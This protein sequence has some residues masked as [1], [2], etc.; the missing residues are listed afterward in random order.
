MKLKEFNIKTDVSPAYH[1]DLLK[2]LY[3]Y[4]LLPNPAFTEA[5]IIYN[6]LIF[7]FQNPKGVIRGRIMIDGGV[8]ISMGYTRHMED[9]V[10]ELYED[11]FLAIQLFEEELEESTIYF[12]WVE[13][14]EIIPEKPPSIGKRA[15][16]SLFGSSLLLLYILF[17]GVNIILFIIL[18]FYA[19]IAILL[20]QFSIILFSDKIYSRMGEWVITPENPLIHILMYQLPSDDFQFFKKVAGED[21]IFEIKKEIYEKSFTQ[22]RF[23]TCELGREILGRYGLGLTPLNEKSKVVDIY[24]LVKYVAFRFG[25]PTPKIVISNTLLPNAAATGPS[26]H[27]GLVL[28]TTG[29]IA[30]LDEDEIMSVIGHEIAHLVGRDPLILFGII[31]GEF[32]LRL[33]I[34]LPIVVISPL[35]YIIFALSLIFFIA[36]FFEARAD[37]LSAIILGKPDKLALALR[38]IGYQKLRAERNP[39]NRIFGWI[40]MDPHPPLYFRIKRLEQLKIEEIK[41]PL[42]RS[43]KDVLNGFIESIKSF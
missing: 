35:I 30:H 18:G 10:E 5:R 40:G 19:V 15:S 12:A 34:L 8:N 25:I 39:F 28:I 43:A 38:K 22:E 23:P 13:G 9:M 29:L 24:S 41:N 37:L 6:K 31:S 11:L 20:L 17:F 33:T 14:Q 42:L 7:V 1:G 26:P 27:R 2:F 36:K 4:Y 3:K 32:I 21:A 16:K